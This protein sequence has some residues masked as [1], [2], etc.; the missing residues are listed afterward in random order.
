MDF[1]LTKSD[2]RDIKAIGEKLKNAPDGKFTDEE[3]QQ[4]QNLITLLVERKVILLTHNTAG[5]IYILIGDYDIF[6][7]WILQ[8]NKKAKKELR[9][10]WW[11]PIVTAVVGAVVGAIVGAI[12]TKLLS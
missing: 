4:R 8:E 6:E 2:I 1:P 7:K 11:N 9:L 10:K 12:V 5:W 3:Y